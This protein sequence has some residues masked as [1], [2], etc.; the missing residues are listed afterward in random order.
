M[1]RPDLEQFLS[2]AREC[3]RTER[4]EKAEEFARQAL[5]LDATSSEAH[6]L[7]GIA[8]SKLGRAHEATEEL[9]RATELAPDSPRAHFNLAAHLYQI[10][11][12]AGALEAVR[13]ALSLN[14]NH[15][16]AL[17]LQQQIE[18]ETAAAAP[19]ANPDPNAPPPVIASQPSYEPSAPQYYHPGLAP[20]P[21]HTSK[22][23]ERNEKLWDGLLWTAWAL[24]VVSL[25]VLYAWLF[26]N[27]GAIQNFQSAVP[28]DQFAL[29]EDLLDQF[30]PATILLIVT[31]VGFLTLWILDL[32]D[33]RPEASALAA[34][35]IGIVL[36]PCCM[37]YL[38][39]LTPIL[40][41]PYWIATRKAPAAR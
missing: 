37:C 26:A 9:K 4:Y 8:L 19:P 14:P 27:L 38:H 24:H 40:F 25:V 10:R 30:L 31:V 23:I 2:Q 18:R 34:A 11:D 41:I 3:I 6:E 5:E 17:R 39:L 15:A 36:A 7:L 16:G 1:D 21:R 13:R 33:R 22:F 29:F 32:V 12:A 28:S 35:V 20:I